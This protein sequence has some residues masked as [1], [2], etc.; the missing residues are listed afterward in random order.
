MKGPGVD[1]ELAAAKAS[2]GRD[3]RL[4]QDEPYTLPNTPHARR[5]VVIERLSDPEPV[6]PD[7][8]AQR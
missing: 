1:A 4:L 7:D 2:F 8:D 5:L 6:A 3:Y